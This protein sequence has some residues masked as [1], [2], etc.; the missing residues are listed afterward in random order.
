MVGCIFLYLPKSVGH[1]ID[2]MRNASEIVVR[3]FGKKRHLGGELL[4][5]ILIKWGV[6]I[7]T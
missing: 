6:R 1:V 7:W 2:D 3:N 5:W 4:K